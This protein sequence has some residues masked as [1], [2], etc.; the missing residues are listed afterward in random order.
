MSMHKDSSVAVDTLVWVKN[1][2]YNSVRYSI[3]EN[4]KS[5]FD[6]EGVEIPFSQL[7]VHIKN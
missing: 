1:E 7:D 3:I 4:V 5:A 6:R 2:D